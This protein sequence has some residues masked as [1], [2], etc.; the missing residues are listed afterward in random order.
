MQADQAVLVH[1]EDLHGTLCINAPY[2]FGQRVLAPLAAEF[3]RAHPGLRLHVGLT[4][5]F[6]DP[7]KTGCDVVIRTGALPDSGLRSRLL[8]R[9]S[10]VVVA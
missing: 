6:V 2:L 9:A 5:T 4:N 8:A 1:G 7:V 3:A 10:V